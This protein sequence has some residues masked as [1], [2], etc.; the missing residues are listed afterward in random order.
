M[1]FEKPPDSGWLWWRAERTPDAEALR[2]GDRS[3]SFQEL[4]RRAAG[5]A[6]RLRAEG[7]RSGDVVGSFLPDDG[8]A[9]E[10]LHAASAVGCTLLPLNRRLTTAEI[11]NQLEE[12]GAGYLFHADDALV[13]NLLGRL[14]QHGLRCIGKRDAE[15]NEHTSALLAPLDPDSV[16]LLL[17]TS[18][19]TGSP[20]GVP[21][22][23][24]QILANA[25]AAAS[26][27]PPRA[28]DRSL[29]CLPLFHVGGL[30]VLFRS[31]L[32][33]TSVRLHP[34]FDANAVDRAL[35]T[36]SIADVS[37]VATL[38]ERLLA[39]RGARS[40][41]SSLRRV[42]LGGGPA[43]KALLARAK[44]L[45]FPVALTYGMTEAASQVATARP[46]EISGRLTPLPGVEVRVVAEGRDVE[47]G[48]AGEILLRGPTLL[49]RYW[50]RGGNDG[51]AFI[52][53]WFRTGDLGRLDRDGD[54]SV[55][56]RRVD[57][58]VSGGEN[59]SPAEIEA[60]LLRCAD[61]EDACV[62]GVPDAEYGQR[63]AAWVVLKTGAR[64][65][66]PDLA[67][68]CREHLAG[69]KVPVRFERRAA[70]PRNAGG[71]LVRHRVVSQSGD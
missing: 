31:V 26:V 54:L 57:L 51:D 32:F 44:E 24:G 40:A 39:L 43:S 8:S 68:H 30:S 6:R 56:E 35:E 69:F 71:K 41:P 60:V 18:G 17:Y 61:V 38:L 33:G 5:V 46:G 37:L 64:F 2:V 4:A 25:Q 59:V 63:P 16:W 53:D 36:E 58:I 22:R 27:F 47:P 20:K 12:S 28:G 67:R 52:G 29:G 42:L 62:A 13:Q 66:A 70:L 23:Y 48:C 15:P 50:G 3:F 7:V 19:T 1:P 11:A 34:R 65:S 45:G 49:H 10:L 14:A 9:V 21:L 55:N